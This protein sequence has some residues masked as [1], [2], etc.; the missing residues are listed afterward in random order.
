MNNPIIEFKDISYSYGEGHLRRQVL[1]S[2]TGTVSAGEVVII[3]GPSGSGKTTFLTL[4]GALRR[5]QE[6]S[7]NLLGWELYG[8][9][10]KV[11]REVRQNIGFIFQLHNLID[12]LTAHQNLMMGLRLHPEIRS[13]SEAADNILEQVGLGDH[14]DKFPRQLS[15]GQRQR[16][17]IARALVMRPKI[18]LADEPTAL[19]DGKTGRVIV[20]QLH[21]LATKQGATVLLVT[22]D[23]RVLDIADRVLALEDGRFVDMTIGEAG[24]TGLLK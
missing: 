7:V 4:I 8:A 3:T 16:V 20:E 5:L 19:L 23:P 9:S 2:L 24:R 18:I 14:I 1:F 22:Y 11:L 15:G 13:P 17:A 12:A 21:D 6:G 10:Q